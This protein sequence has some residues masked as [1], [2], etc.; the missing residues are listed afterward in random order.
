VKRQPSRT[1][2]GCGSH[3]SKVARSQVSLLLSW[4]ALGQPSGPI[5]RHLKTVKFLVGVD[6]A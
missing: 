2:K 5:G 3:R 6:L 1:T 4:V